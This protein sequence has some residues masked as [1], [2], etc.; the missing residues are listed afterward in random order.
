MNARY[1]FLAALAI[2][3]APAA[4]SAQGGSAPDMSHGGTVMGHTEGSDAAFQKANQAMM[5]NMAMATTGNADQDF[6]AMMIP[7]HQGAIDMA[8][9]ELK[10]GKDA[11]LRALAEKI[12]SDQEAEIA[13][14]RDWQKKN[15][16]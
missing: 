1:A 8:R 13:Q 14:M 16:R 2:L 3:A 10:Y 15:P 11:R 6:V 5:K 12:I 9:V 4:A 7:H